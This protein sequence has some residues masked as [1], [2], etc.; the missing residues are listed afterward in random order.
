LIANGTKHAIAIASNVLDTHALRS[1]LCVELCIAPRVS[2]LPTHFSFL[3]SKSRFHCASPYARRFLALPTAPRI[4]LCALRSCCAAAIAFLFLSFLP[5]L[6]F[7]E[8]E[9]IKSNSFDA[10]CRFLKCLRNS[11]L[12]FSRTD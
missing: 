8:K 4:A 2:R 1:Q 3:R 11:A 5:I 9:K 12:L 10:F 7:F 6:K